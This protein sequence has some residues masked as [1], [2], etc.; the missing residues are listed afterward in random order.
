M[1]IGAD[2]ADL[3]TKMDR[4]Q[5]A[6]ESGVSKINSAVNA[7][8]ATA[9]F[10]A[11][12]S[13]LHD[14]VAAADQLDTLSARISDTAENVQ[15]LQAISESYDVEL[16]AIVAGI[17]VMQDKLG[18]GKLA[19]GLERIGV[20]VDEFAKASPSQQFVMVAEALA[21]IEDPAARA[22]AAADIFGKNGKALA[23]AFRDG[24]GDVDRFVKMSDT[25]VGTI[26]RLSTAFI[27]A[28]A[29]V[30]NLAAELLEARRMFGAAEEGANAFVA[31]LNKLKS[32]QPQKFVPEM[33][34][35]LP[36]DYDS[37]NKS[38]TD[39]AAA[40]I[41]LQGAQAKTATEADRAA[42]AFAESVTYVHATER[43]WL[44]IPQA[45]QS[46][47][48]EIDEIR[49]SM[50]AMQ[51]ISFNNVWVEFKGSAGKVAS[52]I[53]VLQEKVKAKAAQ[54]GAQLA[55]SIIGA[56]QGGG[57]IGAAVGSSLG[58]AI[59][60]AVGSKVADAVGGAIGAAIGTGIM[61]VVGTAIGGLI[62]SWLG[63]QTSK[64]K[65]VTAQD[66][67]NAILASS[68]FQKLAQQAKDLGIS[69]A[70]VF[71]PK[72][73]SDLPSFLKQI[74][75]LTDKIEQVKSLKA[76]IAA[77]TEAT[78]VDFD[79]M[80]AI[81]QQFGLDVTKLGPAFQ[82][83]AIDKE[84]QRIVDAMAV[85]E[86]GGADMNGV[87][88]GMADEI[89]ALV[90]K[91]LEMGTTLPENMK[92]WIQSLIDQGLLVDKA[93]KKITDM[94]G[95]KF[96]A[97]MESEM[98]KL[99]K[100]LDAL[101]KKLDE[102][103]GALT[104]TLPDAITDLPDVGIRVKLDVDY[105]EL[106]DLSLSGHIPKLAKGGIV[107]RPTLALIGEAGPE[108]VVPLNARPA[109]P[110]GSMVLN[111]TVNNGRFDGYASAQQFARDTM[112]ALAGEASRR[113]LRTA[114]AGA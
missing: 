107:N 86:K 97:P 19:E 40:S 2:I 1:Q 74:D 85:M 81:V 17:Q 55:N 27:K 18:N 75:L 5:G 38:L 15:R 84:A 70:G 28:K 14:V 82:Q 50:Q 8:K 29:N 53:D 41:K 100:A 54:I 4:A 24:V 34:P 23:G 95:I 111:L 49:Q 94:S 57:N 62:G 26:D 83:A 88:A 64:N 10:G 112:D 12:V 76:E 45:V 16:D 22:A 56:I 37:I 69:L 79:K 92:P 44:V 68:S 6:V 105:S 67:V 33:P 72:I 13:V 114:F 99:E 9:A 11:V 104:S 42:K 21:K 102:L 58:M 66:Q 60:T 61:P 35:G 7:L 89:S 71:D 32:N 20:A 98:S 108:A 106:D 90:Q 103:V 51:D 73:W 87:L 47:A 65:V 52:D 113:G 31:A 48:D 77:L 30:V 110:G 93:G 3:N 25:T 63:N 91:S 78:T 109:A 36:K 46:T 96:G 43:G 39:S 80:N 59:G 101:I